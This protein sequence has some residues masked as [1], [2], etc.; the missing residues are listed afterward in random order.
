ML[1]GE[2]RGNS[3][4]VVITPTRQ[5]QPHVTVLQAAQ[6]SSSDCVGLPCPKERLPLAPCL[7]V[8]LPEQNHEGDQR[9]LQSHSLGECWNRGGKGLALKQGPKLLTTRQ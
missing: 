8:P 5:A 9:S 7:G 1:Q 4:Q 2:P 3:T 6:S